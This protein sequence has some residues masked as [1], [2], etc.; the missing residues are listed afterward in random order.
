MCTLPVP[1]KLLSIMRAALAFCRVVLSA[2]AATCTVKICDPAAAD[3]EAAASDSDNDDFDFSF[4]YAD[5]AADAARGGGRNLRDI[6]DA[7][8]DILD[9]GMDPDTAIMHMDRGGIADLTMYWVKCYKPDEASARVEDDGAI[10]Q[11]RARMTDATWVDDV[12]TVPTTLGARVH[13]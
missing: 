9:L 4:N 10:D 6:E 7:I 5:I 13:D 11:Y 1:G 8:Y 3:E 12:L 2:A